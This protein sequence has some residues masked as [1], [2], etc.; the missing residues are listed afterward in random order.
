MPFAAETIGG[1]IR[2]VRGDIRQPDF[3][4]RLGVDKN[5]VGRYERGERQPDAD[6]LRKLC[7][8]GYNG[9]WLL[10]GEGPRLSDGSTPTAAGE[11]RAAEINGDALTGAIAAV[12]ELLTARNLTLP[13]EKKGKLIALVYKQ[14][15]RN[16]AEGQIER[17]LINDLLDLAS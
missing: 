3:A 6:F 5:T 2:M 17:G 15:T 12:E 8:L 9:H 7:A 14:L 1:R 13:A 16:G 11:P 4:T 10:T